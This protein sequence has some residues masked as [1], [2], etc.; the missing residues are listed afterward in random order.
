MSQLD[1]ILCT[2][3]DRGDVPDVVALAAT[4]E[5]VAYEGAAMQ[6]KLPEWLQLRSRMPPRAVVWT[7]MLSSGFQRQ[8]SRLTWSWRVV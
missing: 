5:D 6:R 2:A 1:P 3:V 7:W 8:F 4:V